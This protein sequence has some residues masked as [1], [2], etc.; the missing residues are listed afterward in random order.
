VHR[1]RVENSE[2]LSLF[3]VYTYFWKTGSIEGV[4]AAESLHLQHLQQIRLIR[5]W[6]VEA[7]SIVCFS[8]H[9]SVW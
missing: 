1:T 4:T 9:T 2:T 8:S 5:P 6:M 7:H 3:P